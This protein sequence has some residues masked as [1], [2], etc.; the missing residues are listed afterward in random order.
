MSRPPGRGDGAPGDPSDDDADGPAPSRVPGRA[1]YI[2][3][4]GT[5]SAGTVGGT[6]INAPL[7]WIKEDFG[8][9]DSRV[10]LSIAAYTVAMAVFVPLAGWMCDRLGAIRVV[11]VGLGLLSVAQ[12]AAVF[13]T[14]LEMLIVLRAVQGIACATFPPGVQRSLPALWPAK[15]ASALAAWAAAIGVGQAMGPPVG[16]LVAQF[17]GW[18]G[19][20]GFAGIF[21][22]LLLVAVLVTVPHIPG[23]RVPIHAPG[24]VVLMLSIGLFVVA[25]T[26]VGQRVA[27]G[28]DVMVGLAALVSGVVFLVIAAKRPDRLL[29]PRSLLE[30]R[31]ARATAMAAATMFIMGIVLSSLPLWIAQELGLGP[32]PVGVIVFAMAAAM[33]TSAR[34]TSALRAKLGGWKAAIAALSALIAVPLLLGA[35]MDWGPG[36]ALV[37]VQSVG[38]IIAL[39]L[40]GVAINAGQSISAFSVSL[41]RTGKNSLAFGMHNTA[42]FMGLATGFAWTALFYPLGSMLLLF[43]GAAVAAAATMS[44]VMSGGPLKDR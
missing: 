30:R 1:A 44:L 3:L 2:A 18:R 39:L 37:G 42:R 20:F 29:P 14:S 24:V 8:A 5:T 27:W 23:R 10:V 36:T 34:L 7:D 19:V 32:G 9:S 4:L 21:S 41:S 38:I 31:Y 16:G 12:L 11:A 26:M 35:W 6:I 15:G 22:A 13:S 40:M 28:P 17:F 25:A 33:A 43:A